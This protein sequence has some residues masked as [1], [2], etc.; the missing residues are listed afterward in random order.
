LEEISISILWL[1]V[2]ELSLGTSPAASKV[3]KTLPHLVP[4][5]NSVGK[6]RNS[7]KPGIL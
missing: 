5:W 7:Q 3:R 6:R 1:K 2:R 4:Y